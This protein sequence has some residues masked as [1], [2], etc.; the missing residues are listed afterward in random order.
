MIE[1]GDYGLVTTVIANTVHVLCC[2]SAD[3]FGR[4]FSEALVTGDDHAR[5]LPTNEFAVVKCD[6]NLGVMSTNPDGRRYV[7]LPHLM[8]WAKV[9]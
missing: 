6:N 4:L 5:A 1:D 3:D 8:G 7:Y 2:M 9:V